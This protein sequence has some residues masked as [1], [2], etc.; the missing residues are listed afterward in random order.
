LS[1]RCRD[2]VHHSDPDGVDAGTTGTFTSVA[3]TY[4][5]GTEALA[6]IAAVTGRTSGISK[7]VGKRV[8]YKGNKRYITPILTAVGTT[9][10]VVACNVLLYNPRRLR[11]RRTNLTRSAVRSPG[12]QQRTP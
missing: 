11:P 5:D 9:T 10:T 6:S 8:G 3:D 2:R 7:N 1:V 12:A 4:L